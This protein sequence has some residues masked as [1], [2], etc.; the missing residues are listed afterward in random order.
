MT[1]AADRWPTA[2]DITPARVGRLH[3]VSIVWRWEVAKLLG[4]VRVRA[5][6]A[7]CLFVPFLVVAVFAV[8]SG[9]PQDT[10]F[11]AWVHSSGF[12]VPLVILGFAGQWVL[13]L[14]TSL[15][16]G[17]IFS[18]EDHF[19]TW[20]TVL[21]RSRS[22][23][24]IFAGKLLAS[25]T[26]AVAVLVLLA[27][28]STA[29]GALVGT[30]PVV[31]LSGQSVPASHAIWLVVSSWSTQAGPVLGFC[32]LG[33][34][35][36]VLSRN[37]LVGVGAPVLIGLVMQVTTLVNMPV[38]VRNALLGTAFGA[39]HGIWTQAPFYRPV[40]QG[41]LTSAAWFAVCALAAWA[42]FR[43]RSFAVA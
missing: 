5:V 7:T 16:A 28:A 8:Q 40:A 29:A 20:K 21:T 43:R 11:G 18:S 23:G 3:G 17:D 6:A 27:G 2:Q 33:V 32:A 24:E 41:L 14:T 38:G 25:M 31:G 12:A 10:L 42:V 22:R 34:L 37:S 15:V 19:T 4:Q 35:L 39:W 13:P 1:L 30:Q 9:V 36:S 26:Y